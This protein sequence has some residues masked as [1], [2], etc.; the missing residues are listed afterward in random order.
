MEPFRR[1]VLP[2]TGA[3][4]LFMACSK[5]D[6]S[7]ASVSETSQ[8]NL[9][10]LVDMASLQGEQPATETVAKPAAVAEKKSALS[11]INAPA[12]AASGL[13]V[14]Q[15]GVWDNGPSARNQAKKL[16]AEGVPAYV[17]KVEN[18]GGL[19]GEFWR[20]RVGYFP[21]VPA[22]RA[23]GENLKSKGI[24]FWI[25]NKS[26]DDIGTPGTLGT[27]AGQTDYP[28]TVLAAEEAPKAAAF[29]E[30]APAPAAAVTPA[31]QPA[32]APATAVAPA[33]QPAPAPAAAVA[34]APQPAPAP[35][36]AD[37]AALD[38]GWD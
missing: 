3:L 38:D 7:A 25:D 21:T 18:P 35:A 23:Y 27:P 34:P 6:D 19:E 11:E 30:P 8:E 29:V 32:P 4:L 13:Y 15:V 5:S 31:P 22:A 1:I 28:S 10:E 20:V 2:M 36:V 26:N 24:A 14:L 12:P 9:P 16:Q 37:D 33:P 17:V